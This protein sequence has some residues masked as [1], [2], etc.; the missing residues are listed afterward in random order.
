MIHLPGYK[1]GSVLLGSKKVRRHLNQAYEE[2]GTGFVDFFNDAF[3]GSTIRASFDWHNRFAEREFSLPVFPAL[4][5][6]W[7]NARLWR[8]A[9]NRSI[10]KFYEFY[11]RHKPQGTFFDIGANDGL[12]TYP[13][14]AFGYKCVC[15]EPQ[16][17]CVDYIR[18]TCDL[19]G[20]TKVII[21]CAVVSNC[22]NEQ[23]Q[24]YVSDGSW[25]SSLVKENV[26][27]F[28]TARQIQV[29]TMTLDTFCKESGMQPDF[30]KIDVEGCEWQVI[31][32]G[33]KTIEDVRPA[34]FLEVDSQPENVQKIWD[35][36]TRLEYKVYFVRHY[37]SEPFHPMKS[38]E[39]CIAA[40]GRGNH[41]D[42]IALADKKLA[43]DF[44]REFCANRIQ[45][46]K[47]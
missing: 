16:K 29:G 31:E 8:W 14:A 25:Y 47:Q 12:H 27:R 45:A 34:L 17:A 15:F 18:S 26:E 5:R 10:R 32:G 24:F 39:D 23:V 42:F 2:R 22:D 44:D 30:I 19:N 4:Q 28:E 33:M 21:E 40:I 35:F 43:E 3:D 7:V 46:M 20:F 6:S 36:L 41:G 11:L 1:L 37:T 9:G 38:V 13:F